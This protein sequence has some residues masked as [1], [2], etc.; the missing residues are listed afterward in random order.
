MLFDVVV[1]IL[2]TAIVS[3]VVFLWHYLR[4]RSPFLLNKWRISVNR[5]LSSKDFISWRDQVLEKIYGSDCFTE[6][7]GTRYPSYAIPIRDELY[8]FSSILGNLSFEGCKANDEGE[9]VPLELE[10]EPV[11]SYGTIRQRVKKKMLLKKYRLLIEGSVKHP[12]LIGYLLDYYDYENDGRISKINTKIGYY[13]NNLYTSHILEYELY[14]A[15]KTL[16]GKV[17][18]LNILWN[19]LPYRSYVHEK[20]ELL[21]TCI[22]TSGKNRASLLS[23]QVMLLYGNPKWKES[24]KTL[25]IRRSEDPSLVSA[26]LGFFQF[27]P[28]GGFEIYDKDGPQTKEII[29]SNYSLT[30]AVFREYLEE[31]F[32]LKEFESEDSTSNRDPLS[33]ILSHP[34]YIRIQKSISKRLATMHL[35]GVCVDLVSLR[36]EVSFVLKIDDPDFS[37]ERFNPNYEY[38]RGKEKV[39]RPFDSVDELLSSDVN[40]HKVHHSSA[41]LYSLVKEWLHNQ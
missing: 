5:V 9:V 31:A 16:K 19:H 37:G 4:K 11:F 12:K 1:S 20:S 3:A 29:E 30:M 26:K 7:F 36:H 25:L 32:N 15:Y 8:P 14:E 23:V 27:V 21:D 28:A 17:P 39:Y 34:E 38:K 10:N 41:A 6:A 2:A 13:E 22:I 24:Y 35:L 18:E 40:S 33:I